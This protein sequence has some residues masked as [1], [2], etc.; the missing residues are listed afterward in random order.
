MTAITSFIGWLVV[1]AAALWVSAF[2]CMAA[3]NNLGRYNIGGAPN[4]VGDKLWTILALG[5][6]ALFW[7]AAAN[8]APFT[9]GMK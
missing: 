6:P 9:I 1:V 7:L 4:R 2:W 3:F 8:L 5:V